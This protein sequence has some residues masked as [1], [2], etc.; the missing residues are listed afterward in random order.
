MATKPDFGKLKPTEERAIMQRLSQQSAAW[1]A[2]VAVRTLRDRTD[3]PRAHDG[4]YDAADIVKWSRSC[5]DSA[6]L[7]D[8]DIERMLVIVDDLHPR[9]YVAAVE[10]LRDILLRYGAAGLSRFAELLLEEWGATVDESG[11]T[12]Q[13]LTADNIAK[14]ALEERE[15]L[16]ESA[17]RDRFEVAVVCDEC[18]KLRRGRRWIKSSPP[19]GFVVDQILCPKCDT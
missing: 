13:P 11:D 6:D 15:R 2:G 18:G 17:A 4:S 1:V 3:A 7:D 10:T 19:A 9:G 8:A 16:E 14:R 12:F 5:I